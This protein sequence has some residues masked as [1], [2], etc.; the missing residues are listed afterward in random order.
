[1]KRTDEVPAVASCYALRLCAL[2]AACAFGTSIAMRQVVVTGCLD[3]P[4]G[5]PLVSLRFERMSFLN[6]TLLRIDAGTVARVGERGGCSREDVESLL[7]LLA[8]MEASI[9]LNDDA[10]FAPVQPLHAPIPEAWFPI[11]DDRRFLPASLAHLLHAD[12]IVLGDVLQ[13]DPHLGWIG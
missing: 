7:A 2:V 11:S 12:A 5:E 4:S 1:M 3:E 6:R 9:A 8:P 13:F 10:S